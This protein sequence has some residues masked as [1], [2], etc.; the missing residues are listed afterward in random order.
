MYVYIAIVIA[1]PVALISLLNS[2]RLINKESQFGS[3]KMET[4]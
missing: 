3:G 2:A 1:W 4:T